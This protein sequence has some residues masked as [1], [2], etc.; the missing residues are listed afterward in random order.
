[1]CSFFPKFFVPMDTISCQFVMKPPTQ[2][3]RPSF[4]FDF[5]IVSFP[6]LFLQSRDS[7]LSTSRGIIVR[8]TLKTTMVF[9]LSSGVFF[10]PP[11]PPRVLEPESD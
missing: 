3:A 2:I 7:M 9:L 5:N 1:M 11:P 8:P 10:P 6:P 4:G